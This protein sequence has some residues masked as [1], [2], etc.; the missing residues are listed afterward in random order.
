MTSLPLTLCMT[1]RNEAAR[2]ARC[3]DAVRPWV[4]EILIA[5]TGSTDETVELLEDRYQLTVQ[6]IPLQE[7]RCC[8]L[9]DARN[10]LIEQARNEWVLTLDGD[11]ILVMDAPDRLRMLLGRSD[12]Y[13]YFGAWINDYGAATEFVDYK[14]FL[15]R[16]TIRMRG[17]I[18]SHAT[19]DLRC[20]GLVAEWQDCFHVM[21]A[22]TL[23][24]RLAKQP[25]RRQRLQCALRLQPG[26]T[27]YHWFL[28]YSYFLTADSDLARRHL[29]L[30]LEADDDRFP[31]ERLNAGAVLAFLCWRDG[32]LGRFAAL[33]GRL[34]DLRDRH[35]EDFEM[36]VN[37]SVLAWIDSAADA[38]LKGSVALPP[39]PHFAC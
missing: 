23:A 31:V 20:K 4:D 36:A 13:G 34:G 14:L 16:R 30:A 33:I 15:F 39:P 12:V 22:S 11:E 19:I 25:S 24:A 17:L 1:V 37:R 38:L 35:R 29:S 5:D 9:A 26:W 8:S 7:C 10:V 27:R 3:L 28:G 2:I 6:S 21:H 32:D 18:H